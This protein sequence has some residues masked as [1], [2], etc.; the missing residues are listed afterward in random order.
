MRPLIWRVE[1]APIAVEDTRSIFRHLFASHH[2]AFGN[3]RERARELASQRINSIVGSAQRLAKA[4]YRGTRHTVRGRDYRHV[5][6]DRATYWFLVDEATRTIRV[7]GIFHGGQDHLGRMLGRLAA[8]GTPGDG[9]MPV[10][11]DT[12]PEGAPGEGGDGGER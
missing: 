12:S 9:G 4:P 10:D 8:E 5:T 3:P 6:I 1:L 11:G 2:R 7:V